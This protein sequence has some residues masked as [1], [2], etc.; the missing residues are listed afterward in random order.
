MTLIIFKT[1]QPIEI[2]QHNSEQGAKNAIEKAVGSE[3]FSKMIITRNMS[4]EIYTFCNTTCVLSETNMAEYKITVPDGILSVTE[5]TDPDYSGVDIEYIADNETDEL[6]T[7]PRVLIE[8]PI[9][10]RRLAAMI[11]ADKDNE[12]YT[13]KIMFDN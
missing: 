2:T 10:T 6:M 9:E 5:C 11:W 7:R 12:D 1:G 3:I 13:H 4:C 8:K